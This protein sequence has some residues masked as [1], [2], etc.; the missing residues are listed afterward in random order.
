MT[1][2]DCDLLSTIEELTAARGFPPTMRECAAAMKVSLT[3]ITQLVARC[4]RQG[5]LSRHPRIARSLV[6]LPPT[7]AGEVPCKT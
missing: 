6:V 4:A 1:R 3:R 7:P 5:R 2:R